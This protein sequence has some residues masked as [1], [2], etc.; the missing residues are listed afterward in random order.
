MKRKIYWNMCLVALFSMI[1]GT[2]VTTWLLCQDLQQQMQRSVMTEVR[3]LEAAIEVGGQ[4][5]L[6]KLASRGDGNLVNRIT[7][8]QADGTVL[9]DSYADRESLENHGARPEVKEA[10]EK[11]RGESVR[12]SDTLAEQTYYYASRLEDGTVIRVASTTRSGLATMIHTIPWMVVMAVAIFGATMLVADVQTKRIVAPINNL[13]PDAPQAE[14]VYDELSPLVRR[15]ERQKD[16]IKQQMETLREKQEEFTAIT[17]NMR[18]GF[19]IVDSKAD[20]I[21][22]NSSAARILGSDWNGTGANVNV[23]SL[24]RSASFRQVVDEALSGRH[25]EQV[26]DLNGRHYQIIANP[27]VESGDKWGAVVVILDVTEQQNREELRREFTANVS[28]ELKTPL[29]SIS[30]YAEIMKSGLVQ[31]ADMGRFSEKIYMEA[32]RLITLVGDIIKLSQLDEEKVGE[33]KSAVDLYHIA[34]AVV[35]RMKD[36]AAKARVSLDIAG[37]SVVVQGAEQILDEMIFNLCD[38][39]IKYN[40]PYGEVHVTVGVEDG[41]PVLTV[42]DTGIGIPEEDKDRIFERFYRVDKSHS[43]QIGGTGLGL[44]IVKH[45]AIYHKARVEMESTLGKGTTVRVVF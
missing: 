26:L 5:Y 18:E 33:E 14:D 42:A 43:K 6:D 23:L 7:W 22:Y 8:I 44:S 11:G 4:D 19:I 39:A 10:L 27:V 31:A 38:N 37:H 40:R 9:Y 3:Y 30:G 41:H 45:G 36:V 28:H 24:N 35:E 2:L 1:V 29:T 13:D 15:L 20:V 21:S 32:Q 12:T 25:S 16:T 17:E 34:G